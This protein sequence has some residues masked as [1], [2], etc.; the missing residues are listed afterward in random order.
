MKKNGDKKKVNRQ[1]TTKKISSV[2]Q[3]R[4]N[5]E[6]TYFNPY[7]SYSSTRV[8]T[9]YTNDFSYKNR[10]SYV[11]QADLTPEK[12]RQ[13]LKHNNRMSKKQ[14]RRNKKRRQRRFALRI[15]VLMSFTTLCVWAVMQLVHILSKPSISYQVVQIGS[16]DTSKSLDGVFLRKEEVICAEQ[17]GHVQYIV[18]EGEKVKKDG[19]VYVLVDE[20]NLVKTTKEQQA[21][22]EKVYNE[23]ENR[24]AISSYQDQI[25]N[26]DENVKSQIKEYF[27]NRDE[28]SAQYVYNL[29]AQLEQGI[30]QR[31]TIYAEGQK[32]NKEQM[33]ALRQQIEQ[34]KSQYQI[35][36][37]APSAGIV[38]YKTDGKET[39][40]VEASINDMTY[41][42]YQEM[43]KSSIV[44]SLYQTAIEANE[45]VYK[46]ILDNKWYVV[47]Y[48][49]EKDQEAYIEGKYYVL[50]F[51]ETANC[52][53][54]FKL[55]SK[56]QEDDQHI[57]LVFET[58]DRMIDFLDMRYA[59][60]T[61]GEKNVTGLK[62]P[63]KAIVEQNMLK[64]PSSFCFEQ[65]G[66]M[67]VYRQI[68]E[69]TEF[70][71]I[72]IEGEE[73]EGYYYI[74]QDLTNAKI[75]QL[76]NVLVNPE[77]SQTYQLTEIET[78][79]GVYVINGK[80]AAFKPIEIAVT[81]G[82]YAIIDYNQK[83]KLKERD[84]II[85]NPKSIKLDQL[86]DDMTIQNE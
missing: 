48:I 2:E 29:R 49:H 25:Y 23:A 31:T 85:S 83:S 27:D 46:L 14:I 54:N 26:L 22:D 79:K 16:V 70:V 64:I 61:I 6:S 45:P 33:S 40:D 47:S 82:E 11:T 84:K 35:G 5:R 56:K 68:G 67:G 36:K 74:L 51:T 53:V 38:S 39:I 30:D 66:K 73:E 77:N 75:L 3:Q 80:I 18:S 62:I 78:K 1:V 58:Q 65:N 34:H 4:K 42:A 12:R 86:L 8:R 72:N 69:T 17:A 7:A 15:A 24:K 19:M 13:Q 37:L 9:S 43:I 59:T 32:A 20:E 71:S 50:D 60:F 52:Q 63:L 28:P 10:P 41:N 76:N 44:T 57:Q 21:F 81:S 55:V